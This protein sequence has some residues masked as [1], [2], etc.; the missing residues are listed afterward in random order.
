[1]CDPKTF[2]LSINLL[3]S[4]TWKTD[5]ADI[6]LELWIKLMRFGRCDL[7]VKIL[8][9]FSLLIYHLITSS[10][11]SKFCSFRKKFIK[12]IRIKCITEID[13]LKF[14]MKIIRR[15]L[16]DW[17]CRIDAGSWRRNEI[18]CIT[19]IKEMSFPRFMS[20]Q[21]FTQYYFK[22]KRFTTASR[23]WKMCRL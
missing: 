17:I 7:L 9:I 20:S 1:M 19:R 4:M 5:K 14:G 11:P 15:E 13:V 16:W 12:L 3:S 10:I 22:I 23:G 18:L 2:Y 21:I 6:C 8:V